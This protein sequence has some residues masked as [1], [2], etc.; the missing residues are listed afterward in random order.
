MA[1]G[2][3][4][5]EWRTK[6]SRIMRLGH[7]NGEQAAVVGQAT[8]LVVAERSPFSARFSPAAGRLSCYWGLS[9][10]VNNETL[11]G[12]DVVHLPST[13]VLE[14][15]YVVHGTA[16]SHVGFETW[17]AR[18]H[19]TGASVINDENASAACRWELKLICMEWWRGWSGMGFDLRPDIPHDCTML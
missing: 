8:K 2:R 16:I 9:G 7:Q 19:S 18:A 13:D 12:V 17:K 11:W 6:I 15:P 10:T 4:L 1:A 14:A 5:S 3:G